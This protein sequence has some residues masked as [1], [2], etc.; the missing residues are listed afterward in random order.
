MTGAAADV[1]LGDAGIPIIDFGQFIDGSKKQEVAD[2]MLDSF[3]TY[4]FVY[5][6]NHGLPQDKIDAMFSWVR[7]SPSA[8]RIV[9]LI[10][11]DHPVKDFLRS[12][13][14]REA[15]CTTPAIWNTPPRYVSRYIVLCM[16]HELFDK[17]IPLLAL[18]KCSR[19]STQTR[20]RFKK[21]A[22][23]LPT[24]KR[25]SKWGASRT[26][27]NQ[28]SGFQTVCSPGSRK[29]VW[30]SSGFVACALLATYA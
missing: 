12:T 29:H 20:K 14:G 8:F 4:G 23:R 7:E 15:T 10:S 6:K 21:L 25:A 17:A 9:H 16:T 18:R 28:T 2:A 22:Q 19:R 26:I 13:D 27:F 1:H 11:Y 3:K 30:T 24:S 5:L